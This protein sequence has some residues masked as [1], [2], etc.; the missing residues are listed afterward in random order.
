M[1][2]TTIECRACETREIALP[3]CPVSDEPIPYVAPEQGLAQRAINAARVV[4]A[5]KAGLV[6]LGWAG[7]TLSGRDGGK[8]TY[9]AAVAS[10]PGKGP[11]D[12]AAVAVASAKLGDALSRI[13][14]RVGALALAL[15]PE[16][17]E[18]LLDTQ[19]QLRKQARAARKVAELKK[20]KYGINGKPAS[21]GV[22]A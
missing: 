3:A 11:L 4:A 10:Q 20:P 13:A 8:V 1:S 18:T 9:S 5:A 7:P 15:G 22:S 6:A 12:G 19:R 14:D 2:N 17:A 21:I 16:V